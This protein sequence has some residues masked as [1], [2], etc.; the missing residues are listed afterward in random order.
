MRLNATKA[1]LKQGK[2]VLG[3]SLPFH[4]PD[5]V[6]L[7]GAMGFDYVT[8][9]LEHEPYSETDLVESLRAAE[10][11]DI[12][13]LVRTA[14]DRDL[15]LRVLDAGAQGIHVVHVNS[16]A[17]ATRAVEATRFFPEGKRGFYSTGRGGRY[18]I[19]QS[20]EEFVESSNRETLLV[21]Q[22]EE[23]EGVRNLAAILAVPHVDA[24]Q[25]GP[26]DLRQSLGFADPGAVWQMV[27]Q[28]IGT[29]VS[30]GRWVSMMGWMGS[31]THADKLASY[32]D[33]GVRMITGQLREFVS[34]GADAFLERAAHS[35]AG[36]TPRDRRS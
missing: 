14:N 24:I 33:L 18:G 19:G 5:T 27:E 16:A 26:K 30:A 3:V 21:L 1:K 11:F 15:I 20:E 7:L 10:A 28:S 36:T 31:D 9:D 35:P 13:P 17:D 4:A 32:R 29:V 25:F 8:F 6:E 12:T 22:I 34:Y 2:T 23:E